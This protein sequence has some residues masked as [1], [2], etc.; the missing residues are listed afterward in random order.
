MPIIASDFLP[1]FFLRNG[2]LQT[3]LGA[4]LPRR[5]NLT[6]ESKRLELP[7]GDFIDLDWAC[8]NNPRLAVITHGLE[9][10]S[11]TDAVRGLSLA[12]HRAG[13]D[14]LAWNFRSCSGEANRLA[15]F[16]HSGE[17]GDLNA[18]MTHAGHHYSTLSLLGISLGGN[19]ILKYL[20]EGAAH[21]KLRVAAAISAPIDLASSARALDQKWSN[22]LYLARFMKTLI[23]KIEEKATR[24]PMEIDASGVRKVRS[25]AEFDDRFTARIH[26]FRDAQDYWE[27]SS[28]R[29][30]LPRIAIRTL[31]LNACDDPFLTSKSFPFA[32]AKAHPYL[33][34]EMPQSGGHLGFLDGRSYW[35]EKRVV[36]FFGE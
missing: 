21:P 17:T 22:R 33:F 26:G 30:V 28:A 5:L 25:F 29:Q 36:E 2:H 6:V 19:M 1:P 35:M 34:L 12:L 9:G 4:L 7:D 11:S 24:F 14:T 13:W 16:Y 3:I 8:A 31:I 27:Q 20:G 18:V 23:A 32:E 10:S 15:R